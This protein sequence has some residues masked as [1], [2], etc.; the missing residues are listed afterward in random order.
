MFHAVSMPYFG[1]AT[2]ADV[3]QDL[4]RSSSVP[5]SG[6]DVVSTVNDRRSRTA[7]AAETPPPGAH[8]PGSPAPD[9][10]NHQG[11]HTPRSPI[12][13]PRPE[14]LPLHT[15]EGLSYVEAVL[16]IGAK[17][18]DGL[19]H[20]H[21]RGLLHRD[22]KPAN[23]LLTDDGQPMLLDFNLA[24]DAGAPAALVGGALPYMAP[25]HLAAFRGEEAQAVDVRGDVY[26]LGVILFELAAGRHPFARRPGPLHE[27][28]P[29]M[30]ADRRKA[31]PRVRPLN[32]A[33]SPA[34]EAVLRRCLHPDP[35]KR[36]QTARELQEDLERQLAHRPLKH[37]SEPSLRERAVKW[38]RRNPRALTAGRVGAVA[39]VLL[40]VLTAALWVHGERLA[41]YEAAAQL[42]GFRD[43]LQ[44]ARL[45]LGARRADVDERE[46]GRATARRALAH[47]DAADAADWRDRPT[48]GR[49]AA[50]D[51][52]RLP[53]EVGEALLLLASVEADGGADGP[54]NEDAAREAL[55]LN[56]R[57]EAC[58]S[59]DQAP[60]A[61]WTQRAELAEALGRPDEARSSASGPRPRRCATPGTRSCWR[62]SWRRRGATPRRWRCCGRSRPTT[63]ATSPP[64]S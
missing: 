33:V 7:P 29:R 28:L 14:A 4:S 11:V 60:R 55:R 58:Y 22:L 31:P 39:A 50:D 25:E 12:A 5:A 17:L 24:Q 2:L 9:R 37:T 52:A 23:V 36:Y 56:E 62:R 18:A 61:L 16:W 46:E 49:L 57:A 1:A 59:A 51:R 63:P 34:A 43:D 10:V 44:Q 47:F 38:L 32:P 6:K 27:A 15:L 20:A 21:E 64:C 3:L 40:A 41:R 13:R 48:V 8:A 35:A 53:A 42:T 19:A 30:L 54:A 26:A 45:L